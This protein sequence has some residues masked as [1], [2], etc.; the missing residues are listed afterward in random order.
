M[1]GVAWRVVA[2]GFSQIVWRIFSISPCAVKPRRNM[3]RQ[4]APFD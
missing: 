2:W 3:R 1:V 4:A